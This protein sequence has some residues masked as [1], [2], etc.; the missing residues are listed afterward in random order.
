M[1]EV[2]KRLKRQAWNSPTHGDLLR[3]GA[4]EIARLEREL[5]KC[6][7]ALEAALIER[8]QAAQADQPQVGQEAQPS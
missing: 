6:A 2:A 8:A 7:D 1:N 5:A 3:A 4:E